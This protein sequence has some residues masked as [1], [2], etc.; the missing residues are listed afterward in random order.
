MASTKTDV[1]VRPAATVS[2]VDNNMTVEQFV[3]LL[4]KS[5][6]LSLDNSE[7]ATKRIIEAILRA[8]S[9]DELW[10]AS[11]G[12]LQSLGEAIGEHLEIRSITLRES[13]VEGGLG[14]YYAVETVNLK[15][16]VKKNYATGSNSIMAQLFNLNRRGKIPGIKVIPLRKVEATAS[17]YHP[18]FLQ[19]VQYNGDTDS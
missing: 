12:S 18:M 7:E 17:G 2:T 10:A 11:E 1:A 13:R 15:T 6:E 8:E 14:Y 3:D 16:N 5:P 19:P 4:S 9:D